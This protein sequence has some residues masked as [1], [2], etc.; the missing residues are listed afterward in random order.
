MAEKALGHK[1]SLEEI[2]QVEAFLKHKMDK[3]K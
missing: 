3:S 1:L 2:E